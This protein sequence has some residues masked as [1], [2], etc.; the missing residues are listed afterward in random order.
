MQDEQHPQCI[1]RLAPQMSSVPVDITYLDVH[2]TEHLLDEQEELI[3]T[4]L[5]VKFHSTVRFDPT[6]LS[7]VI[8]LLSCLVVHSH[9]HSLCRQTFRPSRKCD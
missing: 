9:C 3:G 5:Q 7:A 2:E 8:D 4:P 6:R 1:V